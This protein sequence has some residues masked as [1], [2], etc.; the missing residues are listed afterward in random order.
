[1]EKYICKECGKEARVKP[2]GTIIRSCEHN[3]TILLDIKI[4]VTAKGGVNA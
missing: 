3:G 2:D 1:M 4:V